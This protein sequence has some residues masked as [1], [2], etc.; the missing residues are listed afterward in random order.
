MNK[1][2]LSKSWQDAKLRSIETRRIKT[3]EN[4]YKNP[5]ICKQC[6]KILE[7]GK[8]VREKKFCNRTCAGIFNGTG[9]LRSDNA[10][11]KTSISL[12]GQGILQVYNVSCL[13]CNSI[14]IHQYHNKKYCNYKC[15]Q[16]YEHQKYIKERK[17]GLNL[18]GSDHGVSYYVKRYIKEKFD[19]KCCKCGWCK[20]NPYSKKYTL[21]IEHIDGNG[22]NHRE[23]NLELICPNCHSL[24][25]TFGSLNRG[26]GRD[27]RNE[28]RKAKRLKDAEFE[29]TIKT[30]QTSI[31]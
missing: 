29:N 10:R 31:I 15:Q 21:Q 19:N 24:T 7:Y 1:C 9:R 6:G 23:E 16:E 17:L 3:R 26:H 11:I 28:Q 12:G 13:S 27:Y 14:L 25:K 22:S 2:T 18:G 20:I 5:V 4:Y 8:Q 30:L